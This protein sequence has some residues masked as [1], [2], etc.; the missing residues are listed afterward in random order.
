VDFGLYIRVLWRFRLLVLLGLTLAMTLALL[1]TVRITS[2]GVKY[3][4]TELWAST[5]RLLVTQTGFPEGRL[6]A[7]QPEN[8]VQPTVPI[9]DPGRF[10]NLAILYAEL[11]TSD[12]VRRLMLRDG[13]AVGQVIATPLVAGG[14]FKTQ[15]PMIDITAISISPRGAIALSQRS[16]TALARYLRERQV[17]SE[18]P[19][20][21][22]AVIQ[23]VVRPSQATI[24]QPRSRTMPV[25]VFIAVMFAAVALAFL[26]ENV[27]PRGQES[28]APTEAT[29]SGTKQRRT[30]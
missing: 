14:E 25:V 16:G 4:Q 12:P 30:A 8:G 5:T 6:Y 13:P 1:S 26:L 15:L 23:Q 7:Q 10:N 9:A 18:V 3:R 27:R 19:P 2:D 28:S 29:L 21:D 24:F 22:R 17:A 20:E 11:A